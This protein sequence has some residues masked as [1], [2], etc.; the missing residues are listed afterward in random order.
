MEYKLYGLD[1]TGRVVSRQPIIAGSASEARS[2]GVAKL[3]QFEQVE[4]WAHSLRLLRAKREP[5]QNEKKP[6]R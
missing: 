6:A 3:D 1:R 5:S 2:F 4:V